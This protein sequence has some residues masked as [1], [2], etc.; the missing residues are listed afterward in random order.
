MSQTCSAECLLGTNRFGQ[1]PK[2]D[3]AELM[4][5]HGAKIRSLCRRLLFDETNIEDAVQEVF[6]RA[7]RALPRFRGECPVLNWLCRIAQNVC[8]DILRRQ[9]LAPMVSWDAL[10]ERTDGNIEIIYSVSADVAIPL[11]Q[12]QTLRRIMS[13]LSPRQRELLVLREVDGLSYREIAEKSGCSVQSVREQLRRMRQK[14]HR[15]Y[16]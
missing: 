1:F 16:E 8:R 11:E 7:H 6:L 10:C 5:S 4:L 12:T 3:L 14:L 15:I 9:L 13:M 2:E